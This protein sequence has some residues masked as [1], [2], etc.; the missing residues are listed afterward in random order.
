MKYLIAEIPVNLKKGQTVQTRWVIRQS[1]PSP[2]LIDNHCSAVKWEA[3][4]CGGLIAEHS[5]NPGTWERPSF[6]CALL[7]S[8]C[9]P[10]EYAAASFNRA[11]FAGWQEKRDTPARPGTFAIRGQD[12]GEIDIHFN[13]SG[14]HE[15]I[16]VRGYGTPS[17]GERRFIRENILPALKGFVTANK[18]ALHAIAR[19]ELA[20]AFADR[21]ETA[22]ASLDACAS[23]IPVMLERFDKSNPA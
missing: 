17:D 13:L 20:A 3:G 1:I 18:A 19:E 2:R 16:H 5:S 15:K 22:R 23:L 7:A 9:T 8:D 14:F 10:E 12:L 4:N 6:Q 11:I 21:V